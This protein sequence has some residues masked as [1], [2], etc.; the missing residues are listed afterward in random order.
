MAKSADRSAA[1]KQ[2]ASYLKQHGIERRTG[3]CAV[4]YAIIPNDTHGGTGAFR[5]YPAACCGTSQKGN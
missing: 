4:C 1:D 3:K 5:H 2:R